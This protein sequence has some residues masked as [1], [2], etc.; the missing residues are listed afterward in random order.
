M[1][2]HFHMMVRVR[3]EEEAL[4][5]VDSRTFPKFETFG[6]L[7]SRQFASLF[8]AYT[9]AFNKVYGR[10]GSLFQPNMKKKKVESDI[11]FS[12]LILYI[13]NNP[14]KHGFVKDPYDWPHCSIHKLA[15]IQPSKSS[16]LLEGSKSSVIKWFGGYEGFIESHAHIRTTRS[17]F[18]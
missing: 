14:V 3:N 17:L 10:T 13:H 4:N 2:N 6:K 12:Q 18:D 1:G 16:K 8:S 5:L 15:G 7:V 9:Q 11:Y